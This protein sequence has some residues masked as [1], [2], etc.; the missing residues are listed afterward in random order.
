MGK[1]NTEIMSDENHIEICRVLG[2]VFRG[3]ESIS[4]IDL[5]RILS[6]DMEWLSPEQ[7]EIAVA[8]LIEAGWLI[9]DKNKL[10]PSLE[11]SDITTP[12]GWFP[13][14]SRLLSPNQFVRKE[15]QKTEDSNKSKKSVKS[16]ESSQDTE[17]KTNDSKDPRDKL[18][19]RLLKYIARQTK[20]SVE[21][22]ERRVERKMNSLGYATNW[23]CLALVAREQNLAMDQI[24]ASLTS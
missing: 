20:I 6:F 19:N 22:I 15:T 4:D 17:L 23:I 3:I 8:K 2:L 24:V 9:G 13:R 5:E 16:T 11:I 10:H 7:S 21:E 12:I 18:S 1:N 14:P